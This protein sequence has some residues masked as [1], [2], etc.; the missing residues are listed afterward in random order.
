MWIGP[1]RP[2]W[3]PRDLRYIFASNFLWTLWAMLYAFVWPNYACDLGGG[4]QELGLLSPYDV[5][6][7][8]LKRWSP[9]VSRGPAG[10]PGVDAR[11]LCLAILAPILSHH[12][13]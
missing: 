11:H 5:R 9:G 13:P 10:A 4:P 12:R 8:H 7:H 2:I 6:H 3:R 1:W